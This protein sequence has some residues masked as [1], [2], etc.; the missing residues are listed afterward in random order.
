MNKE[1]GTMMSNKSLAGLAQVNSESD[2]QIIM[3][4]DDSANNKYNM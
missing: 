2:E 1:N 4:P 3:L